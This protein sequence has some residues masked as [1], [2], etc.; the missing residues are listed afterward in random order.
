MH[1][2]AGSAY[3][4]NDETAMPGVPSV[5]ARTRV[6]LL[7]TQ[8]EAGGAQ[9]IAR[10]VGA[11]LTATGFEVHYGFFFRR[12]ASY[13]GQANTFFCAGER[14]GSPLR[15]ARMFM[16]LVRRLR[17]LQPDAVICFQHYGN[18]IGALAARL[19]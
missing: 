18:V 13:D 4:P 1:E 5:V 19:A 15:L 12:T 2:H 14:P 11:G 9:E 8:A 3:P 6:V 7:Q 17:E 10:I 16:A